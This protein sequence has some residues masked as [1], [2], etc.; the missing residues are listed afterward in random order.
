MTGG[1]ASMT[2]GAA[3]MT[4]GAA[5]M[6]GGANSPKVTSMT[7]GAWVTSMTGG[8]EVTSMTGGA[9]TSMTGGAEVTSMT[10]GAEV[11]SMTGG[12]EVTSMTG[13]AEVSSMTGG[14]EVTSSEQHHHCSHCHPCMDT[15]E[16]PLCSAISRKAS[17]FLQVEQQCSAG[18]PEN[19]LA[20]KLQVA[21]AHFGI[22]AAR[23]INKAARELYAHN[24]SCFERDH[25]AMTTHSSVCPTD[26]NDHVKGTVKTG[27]HSKHVR[28]C[29]R[30]PPVYNFQR[31]RQRHAMTS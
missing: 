27:D 5:S 22:F 13:G 31:L 1:A 14:A 7:G 6:T 16:W 17:K 21:R 3:S 24:L 2:G 15:H 18:P 4:G 12:A 8:A 28:T 11:S 25:I 9:E 19:A 26:S 29:E 30:S 20:A 23:T 10:G